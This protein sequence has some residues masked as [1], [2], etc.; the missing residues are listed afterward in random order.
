MVPMVVEAFPDSVCFFY[1]AF[2]LYQLIAA[3]P[4]CK[5]YVPHFNA[6]HITEFVEGDDVIDTYEFNTLLC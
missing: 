1:D 5:N 3:L 6:G 4:R 2:A